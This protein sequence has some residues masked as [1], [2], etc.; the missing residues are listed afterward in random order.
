MPLQLQRILLLFAVFIFLFLLIR[1]FAIPDSFGQYGHY[2]GASLDENSMKTVKYISQEEC[3]QCHAEIAELIT[4]GLHD[5]V[6]CQIC[7]GPGYLH[8]DTLNYVSMLKPNTREHC[9]ICHQTLAGRPSYWINQVDIREHNI[10]KNCIEC[11]NP[12]EPWMELE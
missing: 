6:K 7:H 4:D 2:R 5:I 8:K 9:S 10:E 12:H 3:T 11:H 1:Y